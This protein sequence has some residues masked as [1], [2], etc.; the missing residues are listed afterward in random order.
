MR[1]ASQFFSEKDLISIL[2]KNNFFESDH[3]PGGNF[4]NKYRTEISRQQKIVIDGK[5]GLMWDHRGSYKSMNIKSARKWIKDLNRKR[6]AGYTNWRLPTIEEAASLLE[7][8]EWYGDLHIFSVFSIVQKD[9]WTSDKNPDKKSNWIVDFK[10]GRVK[11]TSLFKKRSYVRA[12]RKI[13]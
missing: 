3:N 4:I 2:K 1:S 13:Y 7:K 8:K 12:V 10:K 11:T 5:T 6:Y 9:I